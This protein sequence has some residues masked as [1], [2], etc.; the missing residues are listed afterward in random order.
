MTAPETAGG[1]DA[2]SSSFLEALDGGAERV[3]GRWRGRRGADLLFYGASAAGE[4]SLVWIALALWRGR[5]R[6]PRDVAAARRAVVAA[7][8]ESLAVNGA[9]KALIRRERPVAPVHHPLPFR[10]PLTSSFPSGHASAAFCA[11]TL[12]AEGERAAPGYYALAAVVATSRLYVQIHHASDVLGGALI[13]LAV[14]RAVRRLAPLDARRGR[15][16]T[17]T[18]AGAPNP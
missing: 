1:E 7:V 9:L 12:L 6:A 4:F 14:G 18:R 2:R 8:V 10:Q 5:R 11:A 3:V 13:G 17:G 16:R 15:R